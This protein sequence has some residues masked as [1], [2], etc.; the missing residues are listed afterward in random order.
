MHRAL[1]RC[2]FGCRV[3]V[4][5]RAS[6]WLARVRP[7][8]RSETPSS[9]G[10]WSFPSACAVAQEKWTAVSRT[11]L[12]LASVVRLLLLLGGVEENPGPRGRFD[13]KALA[14]KVAAVVL[15]AFRERSPPKR[16]AANVKTG[17]GAP[18]PP[19]MPRTYLE[20]AK[21]PLIVKPPPGAAA[22]SAGAPLQASTAKPQEAAK[23]T[24]VQSTKGSAR[25]DKPIADSRKA[26]PR[27]DV[28]QMD[29]AREHSAAPTGRRNRR[30]G[31][32]KSTANS[33]KH[34]HSAAPPGRGHRRRD[35]SK[36]TTSSPSAPVL[37]SAAT[38]QVETTCVRLLWE[39]ETADLERLLFGAVDC[40]PPR[41]P[42]LG[43]QEGQLLRSLQA[44]AASW[45]AQV[46]ALGVQREAAMKAEIDLLLRAGATLRSLGLIGPHVC[47]FPCWVRG[48]GELFARSEDRALH[49]RKHHQEWLLS[50]LRERLPPSVTRPPPQTLIVDP[51]PLPTVTPAG[52]SA[53][54]V[55]PLA[56][57]ASAAL[58]TAEPQ[59]AREAEKKSASAALLLQA[60]LH[61]AREAEKT[62]ASAVLLLKAELQAAQ[63]AEKKSASAALLLQAELHAARDAAEEARL[64]CV[65][66]RHDATSAQTTAT[67]LRAE[68]V[69][70]RRQLDEERLH[71]L[72]QA[73]ETTD[74]RR[75][76]R[77]ELCAEHQIS[78]AAQVASEVA[79]SEL[80]SLQ[81][82][83]AD[84]RR[85]ADIAATDLQAEITTLRQQLRDT[86]SPSSA[87][88]SEATTRDLQA[89][90][91]G[92][93]K[94]ADTAQFAVAGLQV[95]LEVARSHSSSLLSQVSDLRLALQAE[96]SNHAAAQQIS[97]GARAA[98]EAAIRDHQNLQLRQEC[99]RQEA[100][101]AQVSSVEM[102]GELVVARQALEEV[103]TELALRPSWESHQ[104]LTDALR[105]MR[106]ER[107]EAL[108]SASCAASEISRLRLLEYRLADMGAAAAAL[109][110]AEGERDTAL[111]RLAVTESGVL[112]SHSSLVSELVSVRLSLQEAEA[113]L[114][115]R[116]SVSAHRALTDQCAALNHLRDADAAGRLDFWR[117]EAAQQTTRAA[118]AEEQLSRFSGRFL[119][120]LEA[121]ALAAKRSR[122]G[123]P[124]RDPPRIT[125]AAPLLL[126]GPPP[127]PQT[128]SDPPPDSTSPP[129]STSDSDSTDSD[130]A[131]RLRPRHASAANF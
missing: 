80:L 57:S 114:A 34:E 9:G 66:L 110:A 65:G 22:K 38:P 97:A 100:D 81:T 2:L 85:E 69:T 63:D 89:K 88:E 19:S 72:S 6:S 99:L 40:L 36:P 115:L 118:R 24:G 86:W 14:E 62:S 49:A 127:D 87:A 113:E 7:S 91:A 116:P 121:R 128:P 102:R 129:A 64:Q 61:A 21:K 28:R 35:G 11:D 26:L 5:R 44:R 103:R 73:S 117:S 90:V 124:Y 112:A 59:E 109:A 71:S 60:E 96:Q 56:E 123:S 37:A 8:W 16:R 126:L 119:A 75:L 79:T 106:G 12:R 131:S 52:A 107:D 39:A 55:P 17:G 82:K 4:A 32:S 31:G 13:E 25:P 92:L 29:K 50:Q 33:P 48:C 105:T 27:E 68:L 47:A 78:T 70:V 53:S 111:A 77:Q 101:Q 41:P 3:G 95:E 30:R 122:T 67:D 15:A 45:R 84:V 43:R 76:H 98:T 74:L 83:L 93:R 58:P 42:P 104:S 108:W 94:E 10:I 46:D 23:R 18:S 120:A 125:T 54:L 20:A 51:A 130:E 1:T